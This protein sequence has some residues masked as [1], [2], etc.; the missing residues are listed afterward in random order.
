MTMPPVI[1]AI[2]Y[3]ITFFAGLLLTSLGAGFAAVGAGTTVADLPNW[4][5]WA[6][7]VWPTWSSA[8]GL[9]AA[10]HWKNTN[11]EPERHPDYKP[12]RALEEVEEEFEDAHL[13]RNQEPMREPEDSGFFADPEP[14]R[15]VRNWDELTDTNPD[16][17]KLFRPER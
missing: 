16:Q 1:R 5:K 10:T 3:W 2:G 7:A 17:P 14:T 15:V 11:A 6:L 9:T 8:F 12:E 4:Y 13:P